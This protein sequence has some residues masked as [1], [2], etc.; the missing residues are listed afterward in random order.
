[1]GQRMLNVAESIQGH[2]KPLSGYS[3][4][5]L[6]FASGIVDTGIV[7]SQS[8]KVQSTTNRQ[9]FKPRYVGRGNERRLSEAG[10]CANSERLER[11]SRS[12]VYVHLKSPHI[13]HCIQSLL[14]TILSDS[15]RSGLRH[16]RPLQWPREYHVV[17]R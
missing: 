2:S 12:V 4:E 9:S 16:N 14:Y 7:S 11:G 17:C 6:I 1:M 15:S 3:S 10:G 5:K 8:G 13:E